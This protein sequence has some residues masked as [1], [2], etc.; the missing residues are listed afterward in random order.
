MIN[1]LITVF[2]GLLIIGGFYSMSFGFSTPPDFSLF[3]LGICSSVL[4]LILV[5]IFGSRIDF[6]K[7]GTQAPITKE[8]PRQALKREIK[9][10]KIGKPIKPTPKIVKGNNST[11]KSAN[12]RASD[13]HKTEKK[14]PKIRPVKSEGRSTGKEQEMSLIRKDSRAA[15]TRDAVNRK[16]VETR[17]AVKPKKQAPIINPVKPQKAKKGS[18]D[19]E[20]TTKKPAVKPKAPI[21][22]PKP[23]KLTNKSANNSKPVKPLKSASNP[24]SENPVSKPASNLK[25]E[26]QGKPLVKPV[27]K[28]SSTAK[29]IKPVKKAK[30]EGSEVKPVKGS[31]INPVKGSAVKPA[32]NSTI[33]PVNSSKVEPV[34]NSTVNPDNKETKRAP[35]QSVLTKSKAKKRRGFN[36]FRHN[37]DKD[38]EFVKN[39]LERMKKDYTENSKEIENLIDERLDS[40]KGTLDK[41]KFESQEPSIIWSFD[42][43]NVKDTLTDTISKAENRVLMM[44]PWIRNI[45]VSVL[46]KFIDTESRMIIQEASLDDETSVELIKVLLD[47]NVKIRTMPSVHTVAVVADKKNGLI[48]STDPIYESFEVGVVYKDP[49]SI[50]EIEKLFEDAWNISKDI[51]LEIKQW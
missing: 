11:E 21:I 9:N 36:R 33:K 26:K 39:R 51:N 17:D 6:S 18:E 30:T 47:N 49:K 24:K 45:D 32:N 10:E 48:I 41:L 38:E 12:K 44:Y 22:N 13:F 35:M 27:K 25:P 34:N 46:K 1:L 20:T 7:K 19:P 2:G 43:G 14:I 37:E 5:V 29:Q 4:G 42:S 31:T 50:E 23:A 40:F 15:E 16:P 3:T 8:I 28:S